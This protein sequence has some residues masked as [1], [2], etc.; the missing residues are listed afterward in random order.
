MLM[1][2]LA[3][4]NSTGFFAATDELGYQG[5]IWNITDGGGP[6]TT[7]TPRDAALYVVNNAPAYYS[8]YNQLLSS[9]WEFAP[10]NQNDSF[11]QEDDAG[12]VYATSISGGWNAAL[13]TFT[14]SVSGQNNPY[15]YSRFWQP[16]NGVAWGVTLTDYSYTFVA[17]FPTAAVYSDG[18]LVNSADPTTITGS[19]TGQFVVT[20]DVDLNPITNGDTYGFDIQFSNALF[21]PAISDLY[22]YGGGV[23]YNEFGTVVPVP[24]AILLGSIG[25]GLV[26]WLRRRRTL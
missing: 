23:V 8:N 10:S 22:G 3:G 12:S 6:W 14:V 15:P 21:D 2:G 16:D 17:T 13:T 1:S 25:V 20:D 26:G 11:L 7:A 5:T 19:F 9:W 24:G 4:A 18:F